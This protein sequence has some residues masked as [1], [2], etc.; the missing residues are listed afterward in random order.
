MNKQNGIEHELTVAAAWTYCRRSISPSNITV[1][2]YSKRFLGPT[3]SRLAVQM[4]THSILTFA[5]YGYRC[6]FTR[7]RDSKDSDAISG[8]RATRV[9]CRVIA[10]ASNYYSPVLIMPRRVRYRKKSILIVLFCSVFT[11]TVDSVRKRMPGIVSSAS[12][13]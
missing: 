5:I 11:V 9:L 12:G 13:F 10:V 2:T 8:L 6:S 1:R 4:G 3:A 7:Y